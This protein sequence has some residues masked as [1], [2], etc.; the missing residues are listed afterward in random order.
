M[1]ETRALTYYR[2]SVT[3]KLPPSKQVSNATHA[4]NA[5]P[6]TMASST[7]V[8]VRD[9]GGTRSLSTCERDFLRSCALAESGRVL[10]GDGREPGEVRNVK[11]TLSRWHNGAECTVQWGVGTRVT[12]F[13]TGTLLPPSQERPSEGTV[14]ISV[15]LSPMASTLFGHAQPVSTTP[16]MMATGDLSNITDDAQRLLSNRILRSLERTLLIGGALDTEALCVQSGAWVWRLAVNVTVLDNAGNLLDASVLAAVAALRHYRKPQVDLQTTNESNATCPEMIHSDVREPTPLPLHHTPLSISFALIHADDVSMATSSTSTVAALVDPTDREELVQTG[17]ISLAMNVHS[18]VCLLDFGGGC[19]LQPKQ[20]KQCWR[21][22]EKSILQLCRMLEETLTRADDKAQQER[23]LRL[24][25]SGEIPQA[26]TTEGVPFVKDSN[27]QDFME[28][29]TITEW[30][31]VSSDVENAVAQ[32]NEEEEA[33]R[34]KAL[35]YSVGHVAA[36]VKDNREAGASPTRSKSNKPGSLLEAMLQSAQS[37][38]VSS[39]EAGANHENVAETKVSAGSRKLDLIS[40][41]AQDEFDQFAKTSSSSAKKEGT[42]Q[43]AIAMDTDDEEEATTVLQSE[44]ESVPKTAK[45]E[46][47]S[48]TTEPPKVDDDDIDD[49][50]MA[51]KKKKKK[52]KKSK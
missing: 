50:A 22:A 20:L 45:K 46:P 3:P 48:A 16:G 32:V 36:K 35:D 11:L 39:T 17:S 44:F 31:D 43:S 15:D 51:I 38:T 42:K 5:A 8:S 47:A 23:L 25:S 4:Q 49:L 37:A 18:E 1:I 10:R 26:T 13:V 29:D 7:Y 28:I 12:A 30:K 6:L 2:L 52:S 9:D 41:E 27:G 33:Y 21:L 34:L 19:E 40:Q 14:S 24:Q